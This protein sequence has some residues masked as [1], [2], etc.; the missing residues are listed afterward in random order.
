M[1]GVS[2][3]CPVLDHLNGVPLH[4]IGCRYHWWRIAS[5]C[6]VSAWRH[7]VSFAL[8]CLV[9]AVQAA[10]VQ[11]ADN[12]PVICP[13]ICTTHSLCHSDILSRPSPKGFLCRLRMCA[14]Y[15]CV[16]MIKTTCT[17][18]WIIVREKRRE[19]TSLSRPD[20]VGSRGKTVSRHL[21]LS[22][23]EVDD[24]DLFSALSCSSCS[25]TCC[26]IREMISSAPATEADFT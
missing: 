23:D 22:P 3:D 8:F 26:C 13:A 1:D 5:C 17:V 21:Q 4:L 12:K 18:N 16:Y 24:Y 15:C 10:Q 9:I 20:L 25:T 11:F 19:S 6:L 7:L 14:C 2:E